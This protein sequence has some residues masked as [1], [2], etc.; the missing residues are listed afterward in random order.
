MVAEL[1]ELAANL[2]ERPTLG[3]MSTASPASGNRF[4]VWLANRSTVGIV[5]AWLV[6]LLGFAGSLHWFADA[7]NHPRWHLIWL[8]AI[9]S[10]VC[11]KAGKRGWMIAASACMLVNFVVVRPWNWYLPSLSVVDTS[12]ETSV[13]FWNIHG[14]DVNIEAVAR[15]IRQADPDVVA[16][17]ELNRSNLAGLESL[18]DVYPYFKQRPRSDAF[19]L[20]LYSK[21]RMT[22]SEHLS[23]P[24]E[25][26]G[27]MTLG[28][29]EIELW[30]VHV[31]PPLGAT[32]LAD[33][34]AQF[35]RLA[36]DL[37]ERTSEGRNVVVGGDF[38]I[39]PWCTE[40]RN[41][42]RRG[43]L[44]DSRDGHGYQA[45]WPSKLG[46]LGIPI[47]HVLVSP[48][49]QVIDRAVLHGENASDHAG[50]LVKIGIVGT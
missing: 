45:T 28:D 19:G 9:A 24:P 36:A 50:V 17:L 20:G 33:R 7:M 8:C 18:R 47:D 43:G 30:A 42:I 2:N 31:L 14:E 46:P 6:T 10:I 11:N 39:T 34:N 4:V 32:N 44:K 48:K 12:P 49:I 35:N 29:R 27:T 22:W 41:M 38:N 16:L 3:H 40:Y 26:R 23:E 21:H 5:T 25:V 1:S 15:Q 37:A 13:L